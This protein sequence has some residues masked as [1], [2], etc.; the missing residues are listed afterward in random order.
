MKKITIIPVLFFAFASC[1]N[2]KKEKEVIKET[3]ED[4][5]ISLRSD[6]V[7]LVKM[8]DTMVIFESTCRGCAYE[9]STNFGISDSL[10]IVKLENIITTD[11]SSPDMA[12]GSISKTLVLLPVKTGVT[13]IK[14]Y[15]FWSEEKKAADSARF[16]SYAIEVK[17]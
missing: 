2:A 1:T 3:K 7:N 10:G 9:A 17:N 16:T 13:T 6:T 11:I 8:T 15:K 4:N 12:G 5:R 14:M